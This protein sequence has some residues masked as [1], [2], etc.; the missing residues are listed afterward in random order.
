MPREIVMPQLSE[1]MSEGDLVAWLVPLGAK[2]RAGEPIAEIE[3]DKS[4]VELE[5]PA[6]GTL[7]RILVRAGTQAVAVGQVLAIL[8][9]VDDAEGIAPV[10]GIASP[11]KPGAEPARIEGQRRASPLARRMAAQKGLD[12][13]AIAGTGGDGRVLRADVERTL[14]RA[15][16]PAASASPGLPPA[17]TAVPAAGSY[18]EERLSRA[19]RT[20][21]DRLSVA[22][23]EIPHFY[24]HVECEIGAT[25]ALREQLNRRSQERRLSLNDFVVRAA[26]LAL[27]EVPAANACFAAGVLRLHSEVDL[28]IAVASDA[29]L[30][31]PIIRSADRK[32]LAQ[33]SDEARELVARARDGRLAVHEYQGGTFTVSNLGM[34]GVDGLYAIVNPPQVAILGIGR[35]RARPIA[36]A[37]S[38]V[39]EPVTQLSLSA[40][41]RVIDGATGAQLLGAIRAHLEDP[42]SL[43]A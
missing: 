3:T 34:F 19:R 31:T 1:T 28:A 24:L 43:L 2:L 16:A 17:T 35:V 33:I 21:A 11:E 6:D 22:K 29:G 15:M 18:R 36:R 23:R 12:L 14:G 9:G 7:E 25:V 42:L 13:E 38:V 32:S 4:T 40:D 20:I 27:R 41:H 30:I 5:A 26:A 10:T 37:G 39:V 8:R